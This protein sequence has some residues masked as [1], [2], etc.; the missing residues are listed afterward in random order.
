MHEDFCGAIRDPAEELVEVWDDA[1]VGKK[2]EA[3]SFSPSDSFM[4][5]K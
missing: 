3:W 2:I 5:T 4:V 1:N